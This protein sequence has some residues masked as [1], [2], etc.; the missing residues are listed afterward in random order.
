MSQVAIQPVLVATNGAVVLAM[1]C[2]MA[3]HD[4][5][6]FSTTCMPTDAHVIAGNGALTCTSAIIADS[7]LT[8]TPIALRVYHQEI[9]N[10]TDLIRIPSRKRKG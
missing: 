8:R 3:M 6:P 10:K 1:W 5:I 4:R 2:V 9:V 7:Q